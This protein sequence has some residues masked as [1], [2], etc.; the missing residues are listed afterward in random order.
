MLGAYVRH[1]FKVMQLKADFSVQCSV[2]VCACVAMPLKSE[3][4]VQAISIAL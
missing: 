3:W 1:A 2:R 4:C